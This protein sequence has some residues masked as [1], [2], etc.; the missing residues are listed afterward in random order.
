MS[1]IFIS[2]RCMNTY[3]AHSRLLTQL[4]KIL[5]SNDREIFWGRVLRQMSSFQERIKDFEYANKC[6]VK[7]HFITGSIIQTFQRTYVCIGFEND[8]KW[9]L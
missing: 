6:E 3:D 7:S 8:F 2:Y 9:H 4:D 5:D 1:Q